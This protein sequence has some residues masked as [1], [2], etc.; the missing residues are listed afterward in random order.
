MYGNPRNP[1]S[2]MIDY[3]LGFGQGRPT[4]LFAR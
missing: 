2:G 3:G 1:I 4:G